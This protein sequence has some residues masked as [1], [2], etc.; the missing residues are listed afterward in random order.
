MTT[1][2]WYLRFSS[3]LHTFIHT[4]GVSTWTFY[5]EAHTHT[6]KRWLK[7]KTTILG[8]TMFSLLWQK[9]LKKKKQK[10]R[11]HTFCLSI[12]GTL[13]GVS[14]LQSFWAEIYVDQ[15]VSEAAL[16][17]CKDDILTLANQKALGS[18]S[19]LGPWKT[20]T[21]KFNFSKWYLG[22]RLLSPVG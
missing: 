13:I 21:Q 7:N 22:F 12:S 11:R 5:P 9:Y 17:W 14:W 20:Y 16:L 3:N 18:R 8:F 6:L 15:H 2:E 4:Q 19:S 1:E 10:W